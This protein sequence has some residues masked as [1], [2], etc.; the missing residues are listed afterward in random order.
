MLKVPLPRQKRLQQQLLQKQTQS[1]LASEVDDD[2]NYDIV[3]LDFHRSYS[4]PRIVSSNLW[5]DDTELS[6]TILKR[7]EQARML[8]LEKYHDKYVL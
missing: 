2:D 8:A 4:R 7:L 1:Q 3:D 6:D 5:D